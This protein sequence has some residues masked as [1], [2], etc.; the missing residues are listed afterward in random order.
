M[1]RSI[2]TTIGSVLIGVAALVYGL[3]IAFFFIA[4]P[5]QELPLGQVP[6]GLSLNTPE[7]FRINADPSLMGV[8]V[9]ASVTY[10]GS[11]PTLVCGIVQ[12]NFQVPENVAPGA[13]SF[14]PWIAGN[15]TIRSPTGATIA[16][17]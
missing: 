10:A 8:Q 6:P 1:L 4:K 14:S 17:K 16:V 2:L 13:Y 3:A 9:P 15:G 12:I 5:L 11:A 7:S